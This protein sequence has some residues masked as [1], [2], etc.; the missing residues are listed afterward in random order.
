MKIYGKQK[1]KKLYAIEISA[2][3][4]I[5]CARFLLLVYLKMSIVKT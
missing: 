5:N 3:E 1:K 2:V 4:K